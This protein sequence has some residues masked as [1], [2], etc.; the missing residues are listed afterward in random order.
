M[1]L[2]VDLHVVKEDGGVRVDLVTSRGSM[3]IFTSGE[4]AATYHVGQFL[5][6]ID[7]QF[8]GSDEEVV[9]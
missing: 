2:S 7:P 9:H 4:M 8:N 1:E 6:T 3:H 5:D